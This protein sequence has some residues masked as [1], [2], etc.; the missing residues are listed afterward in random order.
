MFLNYLVEITKN[1]LN[2]E[3][4]QFLNMNSGDIGIEVSHNRFF[5]LLLD[6]T[7]KYIIYV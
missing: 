7:Y 5:Y 1:L 3:K 6:N 2:S 4:F